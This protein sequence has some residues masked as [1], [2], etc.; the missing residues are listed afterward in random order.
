M[1]LDGEE[2]VM[3]ITTDG[4]GNVTFEVDS[5]NEKVWVVDVIVP[6]IKENGWRVKVRS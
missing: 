3:M 1:G 6:A 2:P 4:D 5:E